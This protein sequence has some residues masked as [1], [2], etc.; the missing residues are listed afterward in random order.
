M[1][2]LYMLT[3]NEASRLPTALAV[4]KKWANK[5]YIFDK[6][7][8]DGTP[9]IAERE[10][11]VVIKM[12]FSKQGHE[13]CIWMHRRLRELKC[14]DPSKWIL[15]L[16]PGEIPTH[17]LISVAK[18]IVAQDVDCDVVCLPVRL[19][20]FGRFL[21]GSPWSFSSQPRLLN[22]ELA[23]QRN[24][25]HSHVV[26]TDRS[27]M[28]NDS[29]VCHIYHPTHRDYESFTKAIIDYVEAENSDNPY[30]RAKSALRAAEVFD[31]EVLSRTEG[32][33]RQYLAW[34][35]YH[36]LVALR[37][38]DQL[39]ANPTQDYYAAQGRAYR[40]REWPDEPNTGGVK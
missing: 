40:E 26:I 16:T 18:G 14:N 4:A 33:I 7:S 17:G 22:V 3:Y 27:R 11:C 19:H 30:N 38:Y 5:I 29:D 39:L 25:V 37:S 21:P 32:D 2:D 23:D 9:E 35:V 36:Y 31:P 10:G 20:S 6:S 12:P 34:R 15:W 24:V 28:V 13:D 1:L 8:T